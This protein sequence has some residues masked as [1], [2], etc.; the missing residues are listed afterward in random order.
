MILFNKLSFSRFELPEMNHSPNNQQ[1]FYL[2][3]ILIWT[4]DPP[5]LICSQ[6][7]RSREMKRGG[8]RV[9]QY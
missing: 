5:R 7:H 8:L 1:F 4:A 3:Q 2:G 9:C 6:F